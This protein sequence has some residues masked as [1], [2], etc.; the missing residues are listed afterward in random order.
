MFYYIEIESLCSSKTT[1]VVVQNNVY[2]VGES[3]YHTDKK[4][5]INL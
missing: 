5:F 1:T 4:A 3:L 2:R